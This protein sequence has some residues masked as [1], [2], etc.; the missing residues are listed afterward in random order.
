MPVIKPLRS[1]WNLAPISTDESGPESAS[2]GFDV[3]G[4]IVHGQDTVGKL[5]ITVLKDRV[6]VR[7]GM[8]E[9]LTCAVKLK[10]PAVVGVPVMAPVLLLR[11][12]PP[13]KDPPE[14][15]HV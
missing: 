1:V 10:V 7:T 13:G 6:A 3:L 12:R 8:L 11:E 15:A 4:Q 9:S 2:P 5:A 14:I